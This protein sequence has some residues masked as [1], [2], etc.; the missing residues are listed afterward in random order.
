MSVSNTKFLDADDSPNPNP[1]QWA[2]EELIVSDFEV[3]SN[4]LASM[5][6]TIN[7]TFK[8]NISWKYIFFTCN[9]LF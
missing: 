9:N 5:F 7:P 8:S 1:C 4:A 6:L 2:G 3:A